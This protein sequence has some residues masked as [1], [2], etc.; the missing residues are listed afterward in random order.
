MT[1]CKESRPEYKTWRLR[2]MASRWLW[3]GFVA[4]V[5]ALACANPGQAQ[6]AYFAA[7]AAKHVGEYATVCGVVAD[8][9]YAASS[10]G[11]PTFLNLDKRYP[12]QPFTVVIWGTTR[13]R[14][15][16]PP[17]K[18][19]LGKNIC[20]SGTIELYRGKAQIVLQDPSQITVGK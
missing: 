16:P 20:V 18:Q 4:L 15:S 17:E 11:R 1:G 13:V 6:K 9:R 19:L 2:E 14:F 8:A 5:I 10:R 7:E 3:T 12:N